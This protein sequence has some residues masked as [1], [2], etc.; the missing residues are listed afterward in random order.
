M[1]R[2]PV[3]LLCIA[4]LLAMLGT[5][6]TLRAA[7]T[8]AD[9]ARLGAEIDR[10][11]T[12]PVLGQYAV[13]QQ[14]LARNA[15]VDLRDASRRHRAHALFMA[16]Q[17]MALA[18]AAAQAGADTAKLD[19]LQRRHDQIMLE[20]SQ[21]DAAVARAELARQKLQYEAAVQQAIMLQAQGAKA[22]QQ[23]Q[24]AQ[25]EADQ[26]RRLA[27]AQARAANLARQEAKLAEAAAKVLQSSTVV[28]LRLPD[29]SFQT[30]AGSLSVVGRRQVADFAKANAGQKISIE[31]RGAIDARV[32]AGR[33][34]V[35]VKA[36]LEAAGLVEVSILPVRQAEDGA[37]VELRVGH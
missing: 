36:A 26:S 37:S 5:P 30:N 19:Q 33:R 4:G 27:A 17:R 25:A 13:A 24:Q 10:L 35:A 28:S 9:V 11:T 15:I 14:T 23:V 22:A 21:A 3:N 1:M 20:S 29:G 12:D 34:A 18:Q 2:A 6:T 7:T 8:D 16:E 32:L 31:P